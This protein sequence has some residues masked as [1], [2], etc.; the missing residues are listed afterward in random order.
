[1][2]DKHRTQKE[3]WSGYMRT[4]GQVLA[5]GPISW[6]CRVIMKLVKP[7]AKIVSVK[8][9]APPSRFPKRSDNFTVNTSEIRKILNRIAEQ[10]GR[11]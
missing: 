5:V 10:N 2:N 4:L 7:P 11:Q 1:L 9:A 3:I 6:L 8:R